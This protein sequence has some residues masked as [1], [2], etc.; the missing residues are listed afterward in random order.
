MKLPIACLVSALVFMASPVRAQG[1]GGNGNGGGGNPTVQ[2]LIAQV[3]ALTARV[4]KLE[5]NI[6]AADLV[7]TYN[8]T[9]LQLKLVGG[10]TPS[11]SNEVTQGTLTLNADGTT[12]FSLTGNFHRLTPGAP[13]V[14]SPLTESGTGTFGSWAYD[15]GTVNLTDGGGEL[16][17]V[18][19]GGRVLVGGL[20]KTTAGTG[21]EEITILTRLQ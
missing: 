10:A 21:L 19:A 16:A 20:S 3:N 1:N 7:G 8:I 15:N 5:G 14:L 6:T 2:Q 17:V 9:D 18:G 12:S 13:W 11:I 4:A